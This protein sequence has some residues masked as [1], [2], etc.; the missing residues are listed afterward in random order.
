MHGSGLSLVVW[1]GWGVLSVMALLTALL[2]IL[3]TWLLP[4]PDRSLKLQL[5]RYE[6]RIALKNRLGAAP[7]FLTYLQTVGR[8]NEWL[9]EWFGTAL[10]VQAFERCVAIAFIFPIALF[11]LTLTANGLKRDLIT[12]PELALFILAFAIFS[13]VIA[14]A[15]ANLLRI[16]RHAWTRFGGDG[17]LANTIARVLLGAFAVMVAF[18]ISFAIAATFSGQVSNPSSVLGSMAGGFALAFAFAIAFALAG[19]VLFS[20]VIA[21]LA[22][23]ALAFASDFTLLLFLFFVML[24]VVNASVDWLSWGATRFLLERAERAEPDLP[25]ALRVAG[26]TLGTFVSG[27]VLM[28]LLAALLPNALELLNTL[29]GL[30]KLPPFDWQAMAQTAAGAPWTDGL[31]VTGMLM[32][33]LVPASSHL[34]V[35]LTSVL[36]RFTPGARAASEIVSDHPEVGLSPAE[37]PPVMLPL[38]ISRAWY[39]AAILIT[40]GVIAL[41]SY[42]ISITH[43]PVADFLYGVAQCSTSWSHGQCPWF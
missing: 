28:V 10:S 16:V 21:I 13:Y 33:P 18:T 4:F 2:A 3:L 23:V 27:A 30:A 12:F 31:F 9:M 19:A 35:G 15:F 1:Q 6:D 20:I 22:G 5:S 41:A 29:F 26:A 7:P 11:L 37:L 40:A 38:M 24:P 17:D 14:V 34:I 36:A 39:L 25:G 32:T 42:L 43:A 8:L